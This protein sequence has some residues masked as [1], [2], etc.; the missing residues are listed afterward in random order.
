[1]GLD[2]VYTITYF[3]G[4]VVVAQQRG[5]VPPHVHV[6][7]VCEVLHRDRQ[8]RLLAHLSQPIQRMRVKLPAQLLLRHLQK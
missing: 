5:L 3:R 1:M 8:V 4:A 6:E 7:G 2:R